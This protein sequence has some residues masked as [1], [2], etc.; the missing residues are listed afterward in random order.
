MSMGRK[1]SAA[2]GLVQERRGS[3]VW[4]WLSARAPHIASYPA[5]P[6]LRLCPQPYDVH[7][8]EM[9]L[10]LNGDWPSK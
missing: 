10:V 5:V 4:E 8:P 7:R 2:A 6:Y 3:S 1:R 9:L